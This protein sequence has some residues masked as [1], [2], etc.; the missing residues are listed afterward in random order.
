MKSIIRCAVL[1]GSCLFGLAH[2]GDGADAAPEQK[3]VAALCTAYRARWHADGIIT[4]FLT[5]FP[6]DDGVVPP[7]VKVVSLYMDQPTDDN[8]GPKLA[9]HYK[10]KVY[11]TVTGALT[12]GS[13]E[14]AVDAVLLIAEHGKYPR[15]RFGATMY[16]R[17]RMVEEVFR[18]FDFSGRSVPVFM[19]KHLSYSWLDS[20]W[21]YDRAS[22]LEVPFMAGSTIPL[23][24][25]NPPLE[26]PKNSSIPE[27]VVLT[28]ASADSYGVHGIEML[29]CMIERRKGGETGVASVQCVRGNA[30]YQAARDG[31]FSME[32]VEAAASTI[33][34]KKEGAMEDHARN[35]VA[36][37]IDYRD[38]TKGTVIMTHEYYGA[39]WAYA[40]RANGRTVASEFL[41]PRIPTKPG[42]S[43]L[44]LN[45]QEMFLTGKPQYPVERTL[46]ASGIVDVAL[47]SMAADGKLIE[48]PFLNIQYHP[49]QFD[50]IHPSGT[51]PSGAAAGPWPPEEIRHL[52]PQR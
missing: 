39:R 12:L 3:K 51:R 31:R 47:R 46:L 4:K 1:L 35:P 36:I 9:A 45:I 49:Y 38:G 37:I 17:M 24:W 8:L 48:T 23:V 40:A 34:E 33:D 29:E 14:L 30:V 25:R 6:T 42:F 43:Y 20:K 50:P 27:A 22:E 15:N 16:P 52:F 18:V 10:I 13:E 41:W 2:G 7:R 11:P 19:D 32:L 26:H 28:Y 44:G 5:G 21:I